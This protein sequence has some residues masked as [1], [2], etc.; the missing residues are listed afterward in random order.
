M[1]NQM[2]MVV[3]HVDFADALAQRTDGLGNSGR[4]VRVTQVKAD[5][6]LIKVRHFEDCHQMLGSCGIAGQV[7]SQNA[8]AQRFGESA[9]MFQSSCCVFHVE[10]GPRFDVFSLRSRASLALVQLGSH[11]GGSSGC[12]M[13]SLCNSPTR[14]GMPEVRLWMSSICLSERAMR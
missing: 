1:M 5:V 7:F 14:K 4:Y 6:D 12:G 13:I 2:I 9:K 10:D 3:V 11:V 8:Y